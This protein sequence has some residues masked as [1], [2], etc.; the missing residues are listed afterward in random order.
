M[1]I[2]KNILNCYHVDFLRYY[3]GRDG[4]N[5]AKRNLLSRTVKERNNMKNKIR[6][7]S[8]AF[9]FLAICFFSGVNTV[10]S[11]PFY[12]DAII[13]SGPTE[14][15]TLEVT[16]WLGNSVGMPHPR[17]HTYE[18]D[19]DYDGEHFDVDVSTIHPT[20]TASWSW[21]VAG[22][23]YQSRDY[24]VALRVKDTDGNPGSIDTQD[25][26]IDYNYYLR[27]DSINGPPR[28]THGDPIDVN[29]YIKNTGPRNSPDYTV[30]SYL[31]QWR[32]FNWDRKWLIEHEVY[33]PLVNPPCSR[34][35]DPDATTPEDY[36]LHRIFVQVKVDG[37]IQHEN[38][39]QF[40]VGFL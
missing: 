39:H 32:G 25:I 16:N 15:H 21:R 30:D 17:A 12:P 24:T 36:F 33:D 11:M 14:A 20:R 6:T 37:V 7:L 2:H 29:G 23:Y 19:F 35:F 38:E 9:I 13:E 22:P 4:K 10:Q 40:W 1:S 26:T 34:Q 27:V 31:E 8:I 3:N 28:I 18:W 5:Y